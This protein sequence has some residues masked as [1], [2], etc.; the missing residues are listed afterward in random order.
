MHP[1]TVTKR[2]FARSIGLWSHRTP[3]DGRGLWITPGTR[4][5]C[6]SDPSAGECTAPLS[7]RED[8]GIPGGTTGGGGDTT[9]VGLVPDGNP[10]VT[11]VLANG[12]HK[13]F[14]VI[15]NAYEITVRGRVVAMINRDIHGN[16]VR[17]RIGG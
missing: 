5:L 11:V 16:V 7:S 8:A 17:T 10:T 2:Q 15:D 9:F 6:I 12:T 1:A 14:P 13:T 4:D 3:R